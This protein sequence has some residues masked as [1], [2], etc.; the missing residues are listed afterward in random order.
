MVIVERNGERGRD[1]Q[2]RHNNGKKE[3]GEEALGRGMIM[4][5]GNGERKEK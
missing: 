4:V 1:I 5:E 2:E 3:M